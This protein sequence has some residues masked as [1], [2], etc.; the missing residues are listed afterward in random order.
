MTD[1]TSSRNLLLRTSILGGGG[2]RFI[3][4]K[5]LNVYLFNKQK[6]YTG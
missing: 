5:F 3:N 4:E 1:L 6:M 2:V